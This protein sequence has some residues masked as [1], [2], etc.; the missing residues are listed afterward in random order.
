M[1]ATIQ[2]T[3]Y[4]WAHNVEGCLENGSFV[5]RSKFGLGQF[6]N[7]DFMGF[8]EAVPEGM[9]EVDRSLA[10]CLIPECCR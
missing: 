2:H 8:L 9:V 3:Y 4:T 6:T 10:R 5:R 7:G 1:S